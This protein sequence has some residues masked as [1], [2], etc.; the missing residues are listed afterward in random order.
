[1]GFPK[2]CLSY[3]SVRIN[4]SLDSILQ[5]SEAHPLF[6]RTSRGE[7]VILELHRSVPE[8][9]KEDCYFYLRLK[10][11]PF[12]LLEGELS[13][14]RFCLI[15]LASRPNTCDSSSVFKSFPVFFSSR[16][17]GNFS[18]LRGIFPSFSDYLIWPIRA[19]FQDEKR[20]WSVEIVLLS[21]DD[22][23]ESD[24]PP[25]LPEEALKPASSFLELTFGPVS[26]SS[27]SSSSFYHYSRSS[28]WDWDEGIWTELD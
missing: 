4:V 26:S 20:S 1:M 7:P 5:S 9:A 17:G 22:F 16:I 6:S 2:F 10:V 15:P 18:L 27:S 12:C 11:F 14:L 24:F 3:N 25:H 19:S 28:N 8:D 13:F 21:P 23:S